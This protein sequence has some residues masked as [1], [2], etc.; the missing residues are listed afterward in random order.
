MKVK[1]LK[2]LEMSGSRGFLIPVH[3]TK[4]R[5]EEG[6]VSGRDYDLDITPHKETQ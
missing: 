6:L 5:L 3:Y 1:G 4:D 2:L